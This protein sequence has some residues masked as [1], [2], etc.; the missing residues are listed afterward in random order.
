MCFD[1]SVKFNLENFQSFGGKDK[2]KKV[3]QSR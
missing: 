1:I 3:G 2:V